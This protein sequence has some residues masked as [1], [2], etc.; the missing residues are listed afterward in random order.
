VETRPARCGG[1]GRIGEVAKQWVRYVMPIMAQVDDATDEITRV[2]TLPEEIHEERDHRGH[3]LIYDEKFVRRHSDN[4][5][6]VHALCVA[7]PEWPHRLRVGPPS[8]WPDPL[9]WEESFDLT[10]ADDAYAESHPYD[11]PTY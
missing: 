2:V 1:S 8:N 5:P 4:Q 10:E 3:F 7:E 9:N 6:Y 11:P